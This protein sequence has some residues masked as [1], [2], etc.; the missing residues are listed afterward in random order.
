MK[1]FLFGFL[2]IIVYFAPCALIALLSRKLFKIPD[3]IFRK[4][5]HFILLGSLFVFVFAYK[6]WWISALSCLVFIIIVY[7]ILK[8]C[9]RFKQYSYIVTERKKGELK[10]SLIYVFLMFSVV[11]LVCWGLLNDKLLVLVSIYAWG[12]GDALAALIGTKFGKHKLYKKR[13]YEGTIAMFITSFISVFIILL[14]RGVIPWYL[15]LIVAITTGIVATTVELFTPNGL[16]T[17]TCPIA[18][19]CST[20]L[21]LLL[22]GGLL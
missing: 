13:S 10:N 20:I 7:P 4:I 3:E 12:F 18:S 5:L 9:E 19:M 2:M 15:N 16:D 6:T 11:I 17:A 14:F 8:L 22:F 21:M 1:E